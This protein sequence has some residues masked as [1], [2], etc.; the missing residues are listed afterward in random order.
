MIASGEKRETSSRRV[1]LRTT[2]I[3]RAPRVRNGHEQGADR[4]CANHDHRIIERGAG[5]FMRSQD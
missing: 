3:E 5:L 4:A 1:S 2:M